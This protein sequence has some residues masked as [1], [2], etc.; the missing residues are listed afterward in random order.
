M[1]EQRNDTFVNNRLTN[2][3]LLHRCDDG[4]VADATAVTTTTTAAA[5]VAACVTVR[6]CIQRLH[7]ARGNR[8]NDKSTQ[9][10]S[11]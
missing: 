7:G 4:S 9:S 8:A 2:S 3:V 6:I 11:V 5:D 1:T 10:N